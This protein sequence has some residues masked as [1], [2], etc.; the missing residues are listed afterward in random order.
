M[1]IP[2]ILQLLL[3]VVICSAISLPCLGQQGTSFTVD[4]NPQEKNG[5]MVWW[6][7]AAVATHKSDAC[8]AANEFYVIRTK[9]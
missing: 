4:L 6:A 5:S 8:G 2:L 3:A 9:V 1:K 7:V